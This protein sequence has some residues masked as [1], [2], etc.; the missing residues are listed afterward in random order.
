[1]RAKPWR[2]GAGVAL[3]CL[4]IPAWGFDLLDAYRDALTHDA[5]LQ[6]S[7]SAL[8]A[9]HEVVPQARAGLLPVVSANAQRTHNETVNRQKLITGGS[10]DLP[11]NYPAETGVIALKQPLYR[12]ANWAQLSQAEAQVAAAEAAFE[13]D[14]QD[15]GLRAGAAYFD[16]LLA[17]AQVSA[18][19]AQLEAL[20]EEQKRTARALEAGSGTRTDVDESRARALQAK[21]A[22]LEANNTLENKRRALAALVGTSPRALADIVP[23]RLELV[24]PSPAT[25]EPWL[26][27]VEAANPELASLARQVDMA[28]QEIEKQRA[29]HFPTLDLIA[30]RQ[31]GSN[32]NNISINVSYWTTY[33]GM[34]L[35]VPIFN[36]GGV[37][38]AVR[39]AEANRDKARH[40][41]EAGR[42]R[43]SVDTQ[44]FFSGVAQ[45]VE[46]VQAFDAALQS[47]E[48]ALI[49]MRKGFQAGTNTQVDV[50]NALQRVAEAKRA[51]AQARY[52]YLNSRLQLAAAAGQLDD[53]L[54][55]KVN[56]N[57]A[58]P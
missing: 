52:D 13:K 3:L 8:A 1:M 24:P 37:S 41:L 18:L 42:Q 31:Y 23:A 33:I 22:L 51:L 16:V 47:A 53:D 19:Q 54:V 2:R 12:K 39:Q 32:E 30:A 57:L 40:L 46:K 43:I 7:R 29:G 35:A 36:G 15:A 27:E 26:Q 55:A 4:S 14:R 9:A 44:K 10:I 21:A 34:Q 48:Q 6:A 5:N 20:E 25:L 49:S 50:L 58:L 28:N 11:A 45:G 38:A 56:N 17:Q